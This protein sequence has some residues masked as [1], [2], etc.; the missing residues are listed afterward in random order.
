M[1]VPTDTSTLPLVVLNL[2]MAAICLAGVLAVLVAVFLDVRERR[3]W[4]AAVPPCWPPPGCDD[5]GLP[6]ARHG[7]QPGTHAP[8][9]EGAQR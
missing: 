5:E 2:V 6:L 9:R 1:D 3:R 8:T 4:R 7:H